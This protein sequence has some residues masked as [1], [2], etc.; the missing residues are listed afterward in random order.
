[1]DLG[2][3]VLPAKDI[4]VLKIINKQA[5]ITAHAGRTRKVESYLFHFMAARE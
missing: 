4:Y 3:A 2:C 5:G 1:M